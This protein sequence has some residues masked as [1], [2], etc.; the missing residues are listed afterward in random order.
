M[1][2]HLTGGILLT[3][4]HEKRVN[5]ER[6]KAAFFEGARKKNWEQ[7]KNQMTQRSFRKDSCH[8]RHALNWDCWDDPHDPTYGLLGLRQTGVSLSTLPKL[9]PPQNNFQNYFQG[10]DSVFGCYTKQPSLG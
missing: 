10:V 7:Q 9:P 8:C 2:G 5:L 3:L 4:S 1:R 6:D